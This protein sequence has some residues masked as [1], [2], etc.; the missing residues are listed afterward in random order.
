MSLYLEYLVKE[1]EELIENNI[2]FIQ[3]GRRASAFRRSVLEEVDETVNGHQ[4]HVAPA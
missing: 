4:R 3:I 2:R 1:R